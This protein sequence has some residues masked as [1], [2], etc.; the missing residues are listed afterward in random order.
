MKV[1]PVHIEQLTEVTCGACDIDGLLRQIREKLQE[2]LTLEPRRIG[3]PRDITQL[4]LHDDWS[5]EPPKNIRG[6]DEENCL[7]GVWVHDR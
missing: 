2:T 3:R 6:Y 5:Q 4:R 7:E 1:P